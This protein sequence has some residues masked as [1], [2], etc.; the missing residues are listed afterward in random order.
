MRRILFTLP[1]L[2]IKIAESSIFIEIILIRSQIFASVDKVKK[3]WVRVLTAKL[4][5]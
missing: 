4:I 3:H 1:K 5:D 2:N